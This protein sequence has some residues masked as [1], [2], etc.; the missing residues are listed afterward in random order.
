MLWGSHAMTKQ[1]QID[2]DRHLILTSPHPSPFS[3]HKGF[4]GCGHFAK[5]NDHLRSRNETEIN[6]QL[7]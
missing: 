1:E 4:F 2:A 5:A 6:W 3:A 7:S